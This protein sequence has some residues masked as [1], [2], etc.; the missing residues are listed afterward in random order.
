MTGVGA[1]PMRDYQ[2]EDVEAVEAAWRRGLRRPAV[3]AATGLGKSVEIAHLIKRWQEG[4]HWP[5]TPRGRRRALVLAHRTELVEQNA[6]KLRSVAPGLRIGIVKAERNETLADVISASVPTLAS[7]RR[8]RMLSNV[9]LVVVDEAHHATAAS[10]MSILRHYGC[11]NDGAVAAGYTAT[12]TRGDASALGDVWQDVVATRDVAFGVANG[13]LVRPHCI[14]V[15]VDDLDLS[16]VKTS[17]GDYQANDLG[18]AIEHSLAPEAVVKAMREHAVGRPTI[19]FAPLVRTAELFR[20]T[21]IAEGFSA[22]MVCGET[23]ADERKKILDDFRAGKVQVLCNAMVFTEGTDLPLAS[24]IVVARPTKSKGLFIQMVGRGL[25]P[26]RESG[27]VDCLVLDVVG[28]SKRVGLTLPVELFGEQSAEREPDDKIEKDDLVEEE[29][30]SLGSAGLDDTSW[31]NGPLT[32]E[33]VDLFHASDSA[34]MRTRA[35]VWFLAAGERYIAIVPGELGGYD[36][37][38]MHKSVVGDSRWVVRGVSDLA[39]AMAWAEGDV[40][41]AERTLSARERSWR[42]RRPS[43]KMRTFA[44]RLGLTVPDG[45]LSGEVSAMITV[46]LASHRIDSRLPAYAMAGAR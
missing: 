6:A 14:H 16:K 36:V 38:G 21:L 34:W 25:R 27:K 37:V 29:S 41:P 17:R 9:G 45:A 32:T 19:L 33:V 46:A 39:Y 42:A 5:A 8:R 13:W 35:G 10:Y 23:P 1:L 15:R 44:W 4:E 28:A 43:E 22:A 31:I 11:F 12:M 26:H 20:D 40:Q 18:D 2:R 7:E 24:C 3:V 30:V